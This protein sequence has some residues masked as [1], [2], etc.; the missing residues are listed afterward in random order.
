MDGLLASDLHLTDR[1]QDEYRWLIFNQLR[2]F[3]NEH[4]M[5]DLYLLGD[6]TEFKD[7]HSSRLVNRLV[8]ALYWMRRNSRIAQVHIL[9]GNHDGLDPDTPYFKFLRRIP[10]INFYVD[11]TWVERGKDTLFFLPHTR[12]AEE[13]WKDL[14]LG[15]ASHIFI[16]GAVKGAVSESGMEL[17]GI[18]LDMF[19][20]LR[21]MILAGDIHVPQVVGGKVEYVGAPYPI[22]F[23]DTFQPRVLMLRNNKKISLPLDN[24]RKLTFTM[25]SGGWT[26][27]PLD[28][29]RGDQVKVIISLL[30]SEMG[31]FHKLKQEAIKAVE[32]EGGVLMKVQLERR[33][34]KKPV[35][36]A[37]RA[38]NAT[39]PAQELE[40]FCRRNRVD[41]SLAEV[42]Q[43][44]LEEADDAP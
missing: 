26:T 3:S 11:P 17:D 37:K 40:V 42:G 19:R 8:D 10:W 39:T 18:P 15:N 1:T 43:A 44:I 24:I 28:I 13:D 4:A 2:D 16:H 7:F 12:N 30:D 36:K 27:T 21:C 22:R 31:E 20:G 35:I 25:V 9:K 23:G 5:S 14:E 29:K 38:S 32:R 34:G 6:L 33:M 41:Q